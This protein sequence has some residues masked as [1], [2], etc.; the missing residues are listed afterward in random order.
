MGVEVEIF[1]QRFRIKGE[2]VDPD[3]I[4]DLASYVDTKM[5]DINKRLHRSTPAQIA[6]LAALTITH[7]LFVLQ[8]K[9]E[10]QECQISDRTEKLLERLSLEFRP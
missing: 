10:E 6:L 3:Y 5:K 4:K 2:E 7:E 8:R 1:G 9:M